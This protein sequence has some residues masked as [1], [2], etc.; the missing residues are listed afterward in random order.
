MKFFKICLWITL[1]SFSLKL[2]GILLHLGQRVFFDHSL[3]K[4]DALIAALGLFFA[5]AIRV[6]YKNFLKKNNKIIPQ[7]SK[8]LNFSWSRFFVSSAY[9]SALPIFLAYLSI[10]NNRGW[11]VPITLFIMLISALS[12]MATGW[13]R[14]RN[15][16]EA[17]PISSTDTSQILDLMIGPALPAFIWFVAT[18]AVIVTVI[19]L[20]MKAA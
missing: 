20:F 4:S 1:V 7:N 12:F 2:L 14:L 15:A 8:T 10:S 6:I 17:S 9:I 16:N 3:D 11:L 5:W 13:K 18:I 19:A